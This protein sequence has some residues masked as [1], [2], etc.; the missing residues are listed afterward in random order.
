M[1]ILTAPGAIV[2]VVIQRIPIRGTGFVIV[3]GLAQR[4]PVALVPEEFRIATMRD[5]V[6]NDRRGNISSVPLTLSAQ[7]MPMKVSLRRL[8]PSP[9]VSALTGRPCILRMQAGMRVTILPAS[10]HQ[11]WAAGMDT[12]V[13]RQS[14]HA[15]RLLH[16]PADHVPAG[17][18][19]TNFSVGHHRH[20]RA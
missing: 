3:A 15:Q 17:F 2:S 6:V 9:G 8:L 20:L 4:L 19:R 5:D 16:L 12:G 13:I 7:R 10:R 1:E 14:R 11:P 18:Q